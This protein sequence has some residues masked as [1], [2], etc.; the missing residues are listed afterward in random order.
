MKKI[1]VIKIMGEPNNVINIDD[2]ILFEYK[3]CWNYPIIIFDLNYSV[4]EKYIY[5]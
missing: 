4:I 2:K 3:G 5:D 1:E